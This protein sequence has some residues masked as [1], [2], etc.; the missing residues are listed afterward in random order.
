MPETSNLFRLIS[1]IPS[2]VNGQ[3]KTFG[4]LAYFL[5]NL[6]ILSNLTNYWSHIPGNEIMYRNNVMKKIKWQGFA[7]ETHKAYISTAQ[8]A[9]ST[10]L[11]LLMSLCLFV[12]LALQL[13]VVVFSQP[14]SGL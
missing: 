10:K 13:T 2:F 14:G 5:G 1:H 4:A 12:F 8:V 3:G 11:E 9:R 7:G 6:R